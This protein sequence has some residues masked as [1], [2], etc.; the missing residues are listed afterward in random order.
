MR[1]LRTRLRR[2]ATLSALLL[3]ATAAW[4]GTGLEG[5]L[6]FMIRE[7]D[8]A[9]LYLWNG[10]GA[11]SALTHADARDVSPVWSPDGTR[12]AFARES[13]PEQAGGLGSLYTT[14]N[15]CVLTMGGE[16][17]TVTAFGTAMTPRI[18]P[19]CWSPDGRLLVCSYEAIGTSSDLYRVGVD[20][21]GLTK[22]TDSEEWIDRLPRWSPD[23][24]RIVFQRFFK[25]GDLEGQ[26]PQV[27]AVGALDGGEPRRLAM[28][29]RPAWSPDGRRVA[30]LV[31]GGRLL[32]DDCFAQLELIDPDSL[33]VLRIGS[34]FY[35]ISRFAWS[36]DGRG[37]ALIGRLEHKRG[38]PLNNYELDL[39]S[40]EYVYLLELNDQQPRRLSSARASDDVLGWSPSG[41]EIVYAARTGNQLSFRLVD[42]S[43][44]ERR[45]R[46]RDVSAGAQCAWGAPPSAAP[47]N[48]DG[49]WVGEVRIQGR[50]FPLEVKLSRRDGSPCLLDA[51][52]PQVPGQL[53]GRLECGGPGWRRSIR[54]EQEGAGD[55]G[56]SF[57]ATWTLILEGPDRLRIEERVSSGSPRFDGPAFPVYELT[58][59]R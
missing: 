47:S 6:V 49:R 46:L 50:A 19:A 56:E 18:G 34:P 43:G 22:L 16:T 28:G 44:V 9:R 12:V 8:L 40:T 10:Q 32:R 55:S 27:W 21:S 30:Y 17:R 14:A 45:T 37:I 5:R 11:L 39:R 23:G 4:A 53:A 54:L 51:R 41:Q 26:V 3:V 33:A 29:E 31:R 24:R 59:P 2:T 48:L 52:G 42:R 1:C 7:G 15:L 58:R 35:T 36:P 57:F 20:G 25:G 13:R 38:Q